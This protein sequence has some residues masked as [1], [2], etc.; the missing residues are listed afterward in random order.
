MFCKRIICFALAA[1]SLL[2]IGSSALASQVESGS[3][4]CFT[5]QDFSSAEEPLAGICITGIPQSNTGA[6]MLGTRILQPGDILT[7]EQVERMTFQAVESQTDTQVQVCY[8]PIYENRVEKETTMSL[9]VIGK[10]N[11]APV[12]QDSTLE[13]YKNL[14]NEGKLTVSDPEG[15]SLT[16]TLAR[17]PRRGTVELGEDGTFT[18]TPKH[19]KVG[20]DSFTFTAADPAGN[21]SR[22]ATV[23]VQILKPTKAGQYTDTLG[24]DCRFEAEWLRNT[25][26]FE[27]EKVNGQECFLPDKEITKGQFLAMMVE[28]L[29]VPTDDAA[30]VQMPADTPQW[31]KPYLAAAVRSGLTEGLPQT[32]GFETDAPLTGGEAAVMLQNALDLTVS[33]QAL[34]N[35]A[36][37]DAPVWASSSLTVLAENGVELP[38]QET[39]SRGQAAK[40]LYRVN[41]LAI[42]APGMAV[43][44]MAE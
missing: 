31:L 19:N 24:Q 17:G 32:D 4:Y 16:Y 38:C 10:E 20:V 12:A 25:G 1:V 11:K 37:A 7:R 13:T 35:S 6:V 39:L 21:V 33:Q 8:L 36:Y 22:E 3:T 14:P 44:K 30:L 41:T 26:L 28:L 40:V 23:T 18:Y 42:N 27:G 34:E 15:E 29:E 43:F 2:G 5:A 9:A